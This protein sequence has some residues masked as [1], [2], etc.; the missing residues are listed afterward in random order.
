MLSVFASIGPHVVKIE[1]HTYP[2]AGESSHQRRIEM[3]AGI[4]LEKI[5]YQLYPTT[6]VLYDLDERRGIRVHLGQYVGNVSLQRLGLRKP[7]IQGP[8]TE[9]SFQSG[10]WMEIAFPPRHGRSESNPLRY[11]MR[12]K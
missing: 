4:L 10:L 5:A 9:F 12:I 8:S 1:I 7:R 2:V 3:Q 11:P 6:E